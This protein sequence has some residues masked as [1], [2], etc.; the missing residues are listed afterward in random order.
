MKLHIWDIDKMPLF[1]LPDGDT[2]I[3]D[4]A[5]WIGLQVGDQIQILTNWG[6]GVYFVVDVVPEWDGKREMHLVTI[7]ES[8]WTI[9]GA[10]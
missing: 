7:Q 6:T 8:G 3:I 4:Y 2:T 10:H 5:H 1:E 9:K